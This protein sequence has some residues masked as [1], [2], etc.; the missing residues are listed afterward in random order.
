M[1]RYY[2]FI[3]LN[4]AIPDDSLEV[5]VLTPRDDPPLTMTRMQTMLPMEVFGEPELISGCSNDRRSKTP[6]QQRPCQ[7]SLQSC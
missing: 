1:I 4:G 5:G 3:T 2:T 7:R 6:K